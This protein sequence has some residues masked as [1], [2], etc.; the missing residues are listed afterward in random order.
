MSHSVRTNLPLL[1][2]PMGPGTDTRRIEATN[3]TVT[4]TDA[5]YARIPSSAFSSGD[6]T[7]LGPVSDSGDSV[8][9]QAAFVAPA[10]ALTAAAAAGANPTKAEFDALLADVTAL[11]TKLNAALSALQGAGKP[12]AAS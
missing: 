4:L 2:V 3:T 7:D 5:E 9:T 11:R 10:A 1:Q 8:A 6:L 12:M